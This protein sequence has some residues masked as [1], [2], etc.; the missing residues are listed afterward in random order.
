MKVVVTGSA[1]FIGSHCVEELV[2]RGHEV[3]G[4]KPDEVHHRVVDL[5]DLQAQ[6]AD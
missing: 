3:V 6:Q 1:G 4:E 5:D 2:R